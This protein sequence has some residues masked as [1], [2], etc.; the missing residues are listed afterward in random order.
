MIVSGGWWAVNRVEATLTHAFFQ[1]YDADMYLKGS[2]WSMNQRRKRT[3]P[4]RLIIL[5]ILVGAAIYIN[6]VIVPAT[7]P[8]FVP[9]STPTRSPQAFA[10][11]ADTLF[12]EGKLDQAIA[13]YKEAIR[14]DPNNGTY[15]I[16]MARVQMFAGKYVEAQQN[17]EN[18][19]LLN[20]NNALANAVRGWAMGYQGDYL[21]GIAAIKKAIELDPNNAQA[22]AYYAELLALQISDGTSELGA[23]DT[24]IQESRTA[25]TL[26]EN[27]LEVLRSRALVLEATQNYDQVVEVLEKAITINPNLSDLHIAL[28]RNYRALNEPD[29]AIDELLK[30]IPLNPSDPTPE[31]LIS[32]T[33]ATVGE[34][35]KAIEY[36]EQAVKDSPKDPLLYGNLGSQ[37]YSNQDYQNALKYLRLGVRGGIADD[38]TQVEGAPLDYGRWAEYYA[39]YGLALARVNECGEALQISQLL[40]QG[41]PNDEI[42]VANSQAI[43][44]IC[45]GNLTGTQEPLGT[46][47][48]ESTDVTG[49]LTP[50][51]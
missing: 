46:P 40:T 31:Y 2:K 21:P 7:P 14:S 23:V 38:G 33:Y 43:V 28:G 5:V 35:P 19:L 37:Y 9:T 41:V 45:A 44:D 18:A 32:R 36:A 42:A 12:S 3:N 4:W 49:E 20:Q 13:A 24:A 8:L 30:A 34:F 26:N 22:H 27:L 25:M 16:S 10:E 1:W 50:T 51:P 11:E 48:A 6:Q 29:K 17:A 39:R 47:N 15:F